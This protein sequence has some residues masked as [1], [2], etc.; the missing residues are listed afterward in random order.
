[1][2]HNGIEITF[3]ERTGRFS[4]QDKYGQIVKSASLAGIK[5]ALDKVAVTESF[6][7]WIEFSY[8]RT[9]AH[10]KV[11]VIG[12]KQPRKNEWQGK[13][14]WVLD[15]GELRATVYADTPENIAALANLVAVRVRHEAE[16]KEIRDRHTAEIQAAEVSIQIKTPGSSK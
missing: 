7:A 15:N 8:S 5:K 14:K 16:Y 4:A 2:D 3:N 10:R 9:T 12:I 13:Q 6:T 1:M 11:T